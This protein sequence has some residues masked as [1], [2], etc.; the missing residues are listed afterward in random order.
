MN[1]LS[2]GCGRDVGLISSRCEKDQLCFSLFLLSSSQASTTLSSHEW[3]AFNHR[4]VDS[5]HFRRGSRWVKEERALM[6]EEK[7][8]PSSSLSLSPSPLSSN[9]H[10]FVL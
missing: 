5:I 6:K 3:Y 4:L 2:I 10:S 7:D 8:S 1:L 9:A